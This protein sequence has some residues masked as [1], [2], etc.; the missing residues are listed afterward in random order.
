MMALL[1]WEG[2]D[3]STTSS[4]LRH[5]LLERTCLWMYKVRI[6]LSLFRRSPSKAHQ[7]TVSN[8]LDTL[9]TFTLLRYVEDYYG[10]ST[11][12]KN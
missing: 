8:T 5:C 10:D 12:K 7:Y 1:Q 11:Q 4:C 2:A 6:S 3:L 9:F